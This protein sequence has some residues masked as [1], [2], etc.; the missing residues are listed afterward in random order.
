M[1]QGTDRQEG[2]APRRQALT[3]IGAIFAVA[4]IGWASGLALEV[5]TTPER[6]RA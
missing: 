5:V 4:A 6:Q 2:N 3:I 1:T